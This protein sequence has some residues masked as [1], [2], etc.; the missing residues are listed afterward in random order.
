[1]EDRKPPIKP[2][3]KRISRTPVHTQTNIHTAPGLPGVISPIKTNPTN[4][5]HLQA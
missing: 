2:E 1:M 3:A 5:N 4:N